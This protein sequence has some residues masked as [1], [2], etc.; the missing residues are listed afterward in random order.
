MER[1]RAGL[2]RWRASESSRC[3][4]DHVAALVAGKV[5]A[6][7]VGGGDAQACE[8]KRIV[9]VEALFVEQRKTHQLT[10]A[11]AKQQEEKEQRLLEELSGLNRA[12]QE[13]LARIE[14]IKQHREQAAG[15]AEIA[16]PDL[17]A[18]AAG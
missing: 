16:L 2:R 1:Q 8:L 7:R 5:R 11:Q 4:P 6:G 18:R 17:V 15:A 3:F 12:E 9:E 14:G 13:T 10:L